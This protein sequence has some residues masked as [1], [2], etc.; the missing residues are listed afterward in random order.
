VQGSG[1]ALL[2][3]VHRHSRGGFEENHKDALCP[4]WGSKKFSFNHKSQNY[5]L[6]DLSPEI[7]SFMYLSL[8]YFSTE[9]LIIFNYNFIII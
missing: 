3:F 5:K 8:T 2:I 1:L 7:R 4:N 9:F 6:R